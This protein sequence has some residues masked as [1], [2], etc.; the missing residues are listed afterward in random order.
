VLLLCVLEPGSGR[1]AGVPQCSAAGRCRTGTAGCRARLLPAGLGG[2]RGAGLGGRRAALPAAARL[3]GGPR[4][5]CCWLGWADRGRRAAAGRTAAGVLLGDGRRAAGVGWAPLLPA[6]A[7]GVLGA[8][9][10]A[11]GVGLG[12]WAPLL[13]CWSWRLA[14][15]AS[16]ACSDS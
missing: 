16:V 2:R 12:A 11:N 10:R 5:A 14:G 3:L 15:W 7:A 1:R 6:G 8:G 4:T 9:P 13:E